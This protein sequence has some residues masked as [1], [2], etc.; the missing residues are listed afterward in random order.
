MGGD[1]S[2][3]MLCPSCTR[4]SALGQKQPIHNNQ[5]GYFGRFERIR[6]AVSVSCLAE[7]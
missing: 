2:S 6:C 3:H 7:T 4:M 1:N 5:P